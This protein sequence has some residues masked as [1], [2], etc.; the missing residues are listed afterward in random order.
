MKPKH[1]IK[2]ILYLE[3]KQKN[4][5]NKTMEK[6]V[7]HTKFVL[8]HFILGEGKDLDVKPNTCSPHCKSC[9]PLRQGAT[10]KWCL[11]ECNNAGASRCLTDWCECY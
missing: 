10:S 11:L 5:A 9:N 1:P 4:F 8:I 7:N 2:V 6:N 3:L